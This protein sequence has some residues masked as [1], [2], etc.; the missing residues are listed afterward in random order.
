MGYEIE[1][2][3]AS[4]EELTQHVGAHVAKNIRD[5]REKAQVADALGLVEELAKVAGVVE[6]KSR[7][8][9]KIGGHAGAKEG[10]GDSVHVTVTRC[11]DVPPKAAT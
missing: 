2:E 5:P 4:A 6:G 7:Y 10:P 9:V 8:R 1:F 11:E 3:T